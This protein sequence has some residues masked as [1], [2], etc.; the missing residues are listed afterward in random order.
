VNAER[1]KA[2]AAHLTAAADL[3]AAIPEDK[4][5]WQV[6]RE[7]R[8]ELRLAAHEANALGEPEPA[9]TVGAD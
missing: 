6:I 4:G 1:V 2:L 3:A 5:G 7:L 8:T 9:H